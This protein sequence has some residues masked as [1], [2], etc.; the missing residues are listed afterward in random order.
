MAIKRISET[1]S[2]CLKK[3]KNCSSAF[4]GRRRTDYAFDNQEAE[5][6]SSTDF[7]S[8]INIFSQKGENSFSHC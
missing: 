3:A 8:N 4:Q 6:S 2:F 7:T 5:P 1:G